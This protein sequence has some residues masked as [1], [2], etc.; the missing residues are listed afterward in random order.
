MQVAW[1][2]PVVQ[3]RVVD[4]PEQQAMLTALGRLGRGPGPLELSGF[5][6]AVPFLAT[7]SGTVAPDVDELAADLDGAGTVTA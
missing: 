2:H 7:P 6:A 3:R 1:E 5:H 4:D